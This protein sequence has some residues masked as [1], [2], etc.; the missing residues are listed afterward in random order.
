[1]TT[2]LGIYC[3]RAVVQERVRNVCMEQGACKET[4]GAE[5]VLSRNAE[6]RG[7]R[8]RERERE[9]IRNEKTKDL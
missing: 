1:M 5:M 4:E 7:G 9:R 2:C 3:R 8:E 6:G